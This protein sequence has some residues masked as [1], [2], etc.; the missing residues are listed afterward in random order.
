MI[1]ARWRGL[2]AVGVAGDHAWEAEWAR[3]L[4]GRHASVIMDCD[5]AG[6]TAAQRIAGDLDAAGATG[7]VID[8]APDREDGYDLTDWLAD[9][10]H[11][12]LRELTSALGGLG[13]G[14]VA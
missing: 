4:A 1:S 10:R 7:R 3:L 11:D 5:R 12:A 8:L 9:R 13:G 6:L 14:V 2:P